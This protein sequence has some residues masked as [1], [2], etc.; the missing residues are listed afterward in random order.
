MGK[1]DWSLEKGE[2][3][4]RITAIAKGNWIFVT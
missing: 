4:L 1:W 2:H 3:S